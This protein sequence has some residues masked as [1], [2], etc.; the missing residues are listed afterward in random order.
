M[1][2][3]LIA[4]PTEYFRSIVH[5]VRLLIHSMTIDACRL[6]AAGARRAARRAYSFWAARLRRWVSDSALPVLRSPPTQNPDVQAGSSP[7][8]AT[9]EDGHGPLFFYASRRY[10]QASWR[11]CPLRCCERCSRCRKAELISD[12]ALWIADVI[13][14]RFA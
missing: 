3:I 8:T 4:N 14:D 1:S 11:Y 7:H 2:L 5:L 13:S 12:Q 9:S 6:R 10:R